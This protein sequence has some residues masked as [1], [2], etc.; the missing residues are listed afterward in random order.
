MIVD[1]DVSPHTPELRGEHEAVLEHVLGDHRR[2]VGQS[3]EQHELSLEIRG[4]T[5]VR[6][7][8]DIGRTQGALAG[9][10]QPIGARLD[11]A[12]HG[13]KLH[14]RHAQISGVDAVNRHG[15]AR[16]GAAHQKRPASILSPTVVCSQG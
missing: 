15:A 8:L 11:L 6:Q 12:A 4:E 13:A 9:D 2:A 14:D 1:G 7:R 5:G 10:T 3:G 16:Q